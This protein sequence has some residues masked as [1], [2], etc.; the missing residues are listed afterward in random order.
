MIKGNT[1]STFHCWQAQ[2]AQG[3]RPG[4]ASK[5]PG[6]LRDQERRCETALVS[7]YLLLLSR[8]ERKGTIIPV[9]A[10]RD[11]RTDTR[12]TRL[13]D[14]DDLQDQGNDSVKQG[15]TLFY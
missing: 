1:T 15:T 6:G 9:S 10:Q 3:N 8:M 12:A 11:A 5:D 14:R 7:Y 4:G 13:V 2:A